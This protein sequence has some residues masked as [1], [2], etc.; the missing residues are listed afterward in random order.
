MVGAQIRMVVTMRRKQALDTAIKREV[1]VLILER[2]L[3]LL[4]AF[5]LT[6]VRKA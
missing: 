1:W 5:V 4:Q 3:R 2:A 6:W